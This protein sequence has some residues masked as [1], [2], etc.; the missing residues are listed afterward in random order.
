MIFQYKHEFMKQSSWFKPCGK[1][2]EVFFLPQVFFLIFKLF[3][4]WLYSNMLKLFDHSLPGKNG[5]IFTTINLKMHNILKTFNNP[6]KFK[7]FK[8]LSL[9][10]Y[11]IAT[12]RWNFFYLMQNTKV[13]MCQSLPLFSLADHM[14]FTRMWGDCTIGPYR[15]ISAQLQYWCLPNKK[16][17]LFHTSIH[18]WMSSWLNLYVKIKPQVS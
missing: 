4:P 16:K 8:A 5:Y 15:N 12:F 18:I 13:T 2:L 14:T 3:L 10:S 9:C 6:L 17:N 11:N 7:P 1:K